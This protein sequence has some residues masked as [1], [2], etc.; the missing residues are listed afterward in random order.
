MSKL[1]I[2]F[3]SKLS[4]LLGSVILT[5]LVALLRNKK[6]KPM[7]RNRTQIFQ[8][9]IWYVVYR[10]NLTTG[11]PEDSTFVYADGYKQGARFDDMW[12]CGRAEVRDVTFLTLSR[13]FDWSLHPG[14][15]AVLVLV[16][17][18]ND[19]LNE[20]D[21]Y[22]VDAN[23]VEVEPRN[24]KP[25]KK[26][27]HPEKAHHHVCSK[28]KR[29][30]RCVSD[31]CSGIKKEC[32]VC[33][34]ARLALYK[35]KIKGTPT[36]NYRNLAVSGSWK[37]YAVHDELVIEDVM[38]R[39]YFNDTTNVQNGA[40]NAEAPT[41]REENVPTERPNQRLNIRLNGANSIN[42]TE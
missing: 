12:S 38:R 24:N 2:I 7:P 42:W 25:K 3:L 29:T 41:G 23:G 11:L 40:G 13:D 15:S 31:Y 26:V 10:R 1:T 18:I 17:T 34:K 37:Q 30:S 8:D 5:S 27:N 35:E 32:P 9:E 20:A 4:F 39:L 14:R 28:C 22:F 6:N 19:L 36:T 21:F 33:T 16:T